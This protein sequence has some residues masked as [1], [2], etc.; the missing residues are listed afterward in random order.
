MSLVDAINIPPE[1]W[2]Y[3]AKKEWDKF[4]FVLRSIL[5]KTLTSAERYLF[6]GY[7]VMKIEDIDWLSDNY[8]L[9]EKILRC[10]TPA[11]AEIVCASE[12]ASVL[13]WRIVISLVIL[14]SMTTG[15]R[16]NPDSYD[17]DFTANLMLE[18]DIAD[19]G[20]K[21]K[22]VKEILETVMLVLYESR[23]LFTVQRCINKFIQTIDV[24]NC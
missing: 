6:V 8:Q 18:T 17:L 23:E 3:F 11:E 20:W 21:N 9:I 10:S 4:E 16:E 5:V 2:H 13:D 22:D 1:H 14:E 24:E 19:E 15:F 7:H 12:G